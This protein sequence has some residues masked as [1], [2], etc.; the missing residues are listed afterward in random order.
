MAALA[1][2]ARFGK[3]ME[4]TVKRMQSIGVLKKPRRA[5]G[6]RK[7]LAPIRGGNLTVIDTE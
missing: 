3:R 4:T 7:R 5:G 2:A 1:K 6:G